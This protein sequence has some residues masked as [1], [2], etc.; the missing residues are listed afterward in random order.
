M[1]ILK[2]I[3]EYVNLLKEND[4]SCYDEILAF[5]KPIGKN[6]KEENLEK[7]NIDDMLLNIILINLYFQGEETIREKV[8]LISTDQIKNLKEQFNQK[9]FIR[10]LNTIKP[11][12]DKDGYVEEICSCNF[13][14]YL[15]FFKDKTP[16]DIE[17]KEELD[18]FK[19]NERKQLILSYDL[20]N[21]LLKNKM[22]NS[23]FDE[24][25]KRI[26]K[27]IDYVFACLISFYNIK[28]YNKDLETL[29]KTY[30][31]LNNRRFLKILRKD[32]AYYSF[33]LKIIRDI[34]KVISEIIA[35]KEK[36]IKDNQT[37][38]KKYEKIKDYLNC[39]DFG[40]SNL[41]KIDFV[42]L[43]KIDVKLPNQVLEKMLYFQEKKLSLLLDEKEELEKIKESKYFKN[44]F[45][46][47]NIDYDK[48]SR[49]V[50]IILT[51]TDNVKNL[52]VNMTS[53]KIDGEDIIS[54]ELI[55]ILIYKPYKEIKDF[56]YF[57]NSK[58]VSKKFLFGNLSLFNDSNFYNNCL[59]MKEQGMSLDYEFYDETSL[60]LENNELKTNYK[61]LSQYKK[62]G[63]NNYFYLIDSYNLDILDVLLENGLEIDLLDNVSLNKVEVDNFIKRLKLCNSLDISIYKGTGV[64]KKF[65]LGED[66]YVSSANLDLYFLPL[67]EEKREYEDIIRNR[68]RNDIDNDIIFLEEYKNLEKYR[69]EDGL[70]YDINGIV[71]SRPKVLRNLSL[72]HKLN[73]INE[74]TIMSSIIYNSNLDDNM[75]EDIKRCVFAGPKIKKRTI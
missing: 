34:N 35:K 10:L 27:T 44:L 39:E 47:F 70:I 21:E 31:F 53:L 17:T 13:Y 30:P 28:N 60:L 49:E 68:K 12:L 48:L 72:F 32:F 20:Y 55:R 42:L 71:I 9:K 75:I 24:D 8:G 73:M 36:K 11:V 50:K 26:L 25:E 1:D 59:F 19:Q 37:L 18:E 45:R 23:I 62:V 51:E 40:L 52:E 6:L 4:F 41:D 64:N 69:S 46:K 74:D 38:I 14:S 65:L 29:I 7:L 66:F 5:F 3:D 2:K 16:K 56:A 57:I 15:S 63:H 67:E 43:T 61:M 22:L 33:L 54:K 58:I